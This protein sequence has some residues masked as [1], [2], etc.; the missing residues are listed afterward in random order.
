MGEYILKTATHAEW[1]KW[2]NQ[3]KHKYELDVLSMSESLR[4]DDSI[5]IL[6]LRTPK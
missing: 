5:T 6:L 2:L 3:W 4:H 1:Q